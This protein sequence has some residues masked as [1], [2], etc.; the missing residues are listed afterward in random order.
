ME[1]WGAAAETEAAM[2]TPPGAAVLSGDYLDITDMPEEGED[3]VINLAELTASDPVDV[4]SATYENVAPDSFQLA[5]PPDT[6]T[7]TG[8]SGE[9]QVAEQAPLP[10]DSLA[11]MEDWGAAAETEAV[12]V[13]PPGAA[14]LSGDRL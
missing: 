5:M 2:L 9:E 8:P 4:Q 7:A 3:Q 6:T 1:D 11:G 12:V 14:A 10:L 13:T